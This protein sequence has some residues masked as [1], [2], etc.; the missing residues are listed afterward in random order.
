MLH[1]VETTGFNHNTRSQSLAMFQSW[2]AANNYTVVDDQNGSQFNTLANLQQYAVVVFSNTSGDNG[3]DATQRANFEAYIQGGGSY[4]GIHA[5]T[6]TYRHSSANGGSK[7]K[8]DW[9]AETVAGATV[10][11]SPNHT[12]SSHNN[13]MTKTTPGHPTLASLPDPWNK[14]E[15]YYY[16]QNG[17]LNPTFTEL[18]R[19]G[20]TGGNSYDA[21]RM[22][23]HCKELQWGGRTFYTSLG[24][25]KLNFTSAAN[26]NFQNLI[27]DALLWCAAPNIGGGAALNI[28]AT[29]A[30]DTCA[31]NSGAIDLSVS[32]GTSPYTYIWS[33]GSTNQD[34]SGLVAGTYTVTVTDNAGCSSA[35]SYTVASIGSGSLNASISIVA[36][37][38][39]PGGADGELL[40]NV[41]GGTSPY[42]YMW[43]NSLQTAGIDKLSAGTYDVTITDQVG[44]EDIASITLTDPADWN[45]NINVSTPISCFGG[46]D[47]KLTAVPSGANGGYSYLWSTGSTSQTATGLS[48]GSYSVTVT[49]NQGCTT[50]GNASISQPN[51]IS[52]VLTATDESC[53]GQ[54]NGAVSAT[55]S[56]GTGAY[57]YSWS[58]GGSGT[59]I[60]SLASGQYVLTVTD[61][62]GCI[63][64]DSATVSAPPILSASISTTQA[65]LCAGATNG[66]LTA[67][68]TGGTSP[69]T[70]LWSNGATNAIASGLGAG[71]YQVTVTDANGCQN[72]AS[73]T[74][75]AP[76][77][78]LATIT[79]TDSIN[80]F[81]A[82]TGSLTASA[83]GGTPGYTYVWSNTDLG[84]VSTGLLAGSYFVV[85]Q[86]ANGCADTAFVTL[87]EPADLVVGANILTT[88]SCAGSLDGS[89]LGSATGGTA[90]YSFA[91]VAGPATDSLKNLGAG[92]YKLIVTDAKGCVDSTTVTLS[93]PAPVV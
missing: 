81:G 32:G 68:A 40:A 23:T 43:S 38:T 7:G 22:T 92:T 21:P 88:P 57:S 9:Y 48:Q 24:H 85:A 60:T 78:I 47:G 4:L 37:V 93:D 82:A 62:N 75:S 86:D 10:Q 34:L 52:T 89:V 80:C 16:W 49:D 5:A 36:G 39:C 67:S 90:P 61:A 46:N 53:N 84:P 3:L 64:S 76:A 79:I 15:E 12:S 11:Q 25:D 19:V 50:T 59:S 70:Y 31:T 51:A 55:V 35:K 83:S 26:I 72:T 87:T 58:N 29:I 27:K 69:Y 8:W 6:D 17:Y 2:A 73:V 65:I 30:G 91:W 14:T 66:I 1:Y 20:S 13:N 54:G 56:G 63:K 42:Q 44:C 45:L 74:L 33:N 18:L 71:T 77:G 41:S 28:T